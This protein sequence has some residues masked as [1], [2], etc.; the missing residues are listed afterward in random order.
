MGAAVMRSRSDVLAELKTLDDQEVELRKTSA[1]IT[2][3][4]TGHKGTIIAGVL[5]AAGI[6]TAWATF[7]VS[8]A[9]SVAG[10]LWFAKETVDKV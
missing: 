8:L 6:A 2:S 5:T 9:V 4:L 1:A 7:G 10:G 3:W